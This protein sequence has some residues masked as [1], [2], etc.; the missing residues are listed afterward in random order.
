MTKLNPSG[1]ALLYSTYLGGTGKDAT[2]YYG[3]QD[4]GDAI[5]VNSAGNA[6]VTGMTSAMNFPTTVGAFQYYPSGGLDSFVTELSTNGSTLV[7]SSYLGGSLDEFGKGIAVHSS[8]N[9][10]VGGY[11]NSTNFPTYG[12]A[13]PA[14]GGGAFDAFLLKI[15]N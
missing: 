1:S 10:Y 9:V 4:G 13:Q 2:N 12:A 6:Y 5:A 15:N 14:Y 3:D 11:T 7:Y 8:G